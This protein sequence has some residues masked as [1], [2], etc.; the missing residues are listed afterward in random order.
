MH[1]KFVFFRVLSNVRRLIALSQSDLVLGI[2]YRETVV[3]LAW[4]DERIVNNVKNKSLTFNILT[5]E[6]SIE[7]SI[8]R[9][10]N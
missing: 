10:I 4:S 5:I 1:L 7:N 8:S 6:Q 2:H 9:A 3:A